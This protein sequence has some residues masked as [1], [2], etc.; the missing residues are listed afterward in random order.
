L[1]LFPDG[2]QTHVPLSDK[3]SVARAVLDA[4]DQVRPTD[5]T[6]TGR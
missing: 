3:R 1:I 2:Q 6:Q 4:V 5:S